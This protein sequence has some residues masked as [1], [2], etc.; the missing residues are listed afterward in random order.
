[1]TKAHESL[2][3]IKNSGS[4]S[5]ACCSALYDMTFAACVF[6]SSA[7]DD[8]MSDR[9]SSRAGISVTFCCSCDLD[10]QNASAYTFYSE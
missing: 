2:K 7:D 3:K 8:T 5:A 9:S 6:A 4:S 1:M 10:Q